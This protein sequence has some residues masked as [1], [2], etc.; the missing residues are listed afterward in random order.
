MSENWVEPLGATATRGQLMVKYGGGSQ[1]G[2]EASA[3][4]PNVLVYSDPAEG[5]KHGYNYDGWLPDYS[6]FLYTGEG[7][8]GDQ[9]LV[10]GN[11]RILRHRQEE[12]TLRLFKASSGKRPG[13]KLHRYVGEFELDASDP[14]SRQEAPDRTGTMR[15]V[16]VFRLLPVGVTSRDAKDVSPVPVTPPGAELVAAERTDSETYDVKAV[17]KRSAERRESQLVKDYRAWLVARGHEVKRWRI[18]PPGELRTLY[19]DLYDVTANELFEAKGTVTRNAVRLAIGQLLD[20]CRHVPNDDTQL[21]V[22]LPSRPSDDLIDLIV[23]CRMA[24]VF[25]DSTGF[26]RVPVRAS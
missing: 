10:R 8:V 21:T 13:G 9:E 17:D 11:E 23:H 1:G 26:L 2:I 16:L 22:L 7:Q 19:T 6:A 3:T 20:Y 14:Y 24:C 12:R 15:S 25:R 5:E 18:R 4:T